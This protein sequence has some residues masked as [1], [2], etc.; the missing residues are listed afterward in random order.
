MKQRCTKLF[1]K[2]LTAELTK[3][4]VVLERTVCK[5]GDFL[6]ATTLNIESNLQGNRK[7]RVCEKRARNTPLC[8]WFHILTC[9]LGNDWETRHSA[10][11]VQQMQQIERYYFGCCCLLNTCFEPQHWLDFSRLLQLINLDPSNF[12]FAFP[13][14]LHCPLVQRDTLCSPRET[15]T[16]L[17]SAYDYWRSSTLLKMLSLSSYPI[18]WTLELHII[19]TPSPPSPGILARRRQIS[20]LRTDSESSWNM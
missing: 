1:L 6:T 3:A 13:P 14:R 19:Q 10:C 9:K 5:I 17:M 12:V 15:L 8:L 2:T 20:C 18:S 4:R 11:A 7:K 16:E